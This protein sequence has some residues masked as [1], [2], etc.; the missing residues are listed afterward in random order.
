MKQSMKIVFPKIKIKKNKLKIPKEALRIRFPIIKL[1][2][3]KKI[4]RKKLNQNNL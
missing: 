1:M 2:N 3:Y 4:F